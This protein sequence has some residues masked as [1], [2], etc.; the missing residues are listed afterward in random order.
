MGHMT[1]DTW[2][3][4]HVMWH[5]TCYTWWGVN[6]FSK[7]QFPSFYGLGWTVSWIFWTKG[8]PNESQ[9]LSNIW[10]LQSI[11]LLRRVLVSD[12]SNDKY[13]YWW[14]GGRD[15]YVLSKGK[16]FLGH[17][18]VAT[19]LYSGPQNRRQIWRVENFCQRGEI[20]RPN[21]PLHTQLTKALYWSQ[22]ISSLCSI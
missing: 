9:S 13:F 17:I 5:V 21:F 18:R 3:V 12:L 1:C 14:I 19:L 8:S 15:Q 11:K 20:L 7:F 22:A 2:H 16:L 6:I 10:E 4:T